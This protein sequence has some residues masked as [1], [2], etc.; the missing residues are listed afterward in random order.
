MCKFLLR[1]DIIE[2]L[3]AGPA[4]LTSDPRRCPVH[5]NRVTGSG[6]TTGFLHPSAR[7]TKATTLG[8]GA[9]WSPPPS[10][11]ALGGRHQPARGSGDPVSLY[12]GPG[13]CPPV[14]PGGTAPEAQV[15]GAGAR[16][17]EG[18]GGGYWRQWRRMRTKIRNLLALGTTKWHAIRTGLSSKSYW[19][20]SRTLATQTGMTND[21]LQSQ[22]L[23]SMR[24][25][26]MKA[27]GY[28]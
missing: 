25:I 8:W 18:E 21:W 9:C 7:P 24:D 12:H 26:W 28:I 2:W 10:T 15:P 5:L 6:T 1:R 13:E 16:G 14:V 20:L 22:G 19:H 4:A 3:H 23:I 11:S 17:G 27:H